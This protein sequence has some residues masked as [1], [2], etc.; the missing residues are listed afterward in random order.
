MIVRIQAPSESMGGTRG[1]L[2]PAREAHCEQSKPCIFRRKCVRL[3][4]MEY[5]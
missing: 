2:V 4:V 1:E 5:Q 3:E